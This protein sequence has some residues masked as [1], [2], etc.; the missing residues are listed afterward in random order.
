MV[1]DPAWALRGRS[2]WATGFP[3]D[4]VK[5]IPVEPVMSGPVSTTQR[6]RNGIMD[7]S[8]IGSHAQPSRLDVQRHHL[9]EQRADYAAMEDRVRRTREY[10]HGTRGAF[11]RMVVGH[12]M[13]TFGRRRLRPEPLEADPLSGPAP[14]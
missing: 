11:I 9:D 13:R 12:A 6:E 7:L 1:S 5:V 14:M 3:D 4:M 2:A 10:R 8:T